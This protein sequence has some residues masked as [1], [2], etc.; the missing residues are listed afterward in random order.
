MYMD[1]V[2]WLIP[3]KLRSGTSRLIQLS[4]FKNLLQADKN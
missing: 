1:I 2:K 3:Y 4:S